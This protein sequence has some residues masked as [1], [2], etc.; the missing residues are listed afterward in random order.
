M[1]STC[2][3]NLRQ[4]Y[5]FRENVIRA[6]A[7][8]SD[9]IKD[10]RTVG[11]CKNLVTTEFFHVCVKEEEDPVKSETDII[12]EKEI[13]IESQDGNVH[14]KESGFCVTHQK[15]TL[16][17]NP[18][19]EENSNLDDRWSTS[20]ST[21]DLNLSNNTQ[22]GDEMTF[23]S[24]TLQLNNVISTLE[25]NSKSTSPKRKKNKFQ[26]RN[27]IATTLSRR[28][29]EESKEEYLIVA[30]KR[31]KE[32]ADN[33]NRFICDQCGNYFTCSHYFKLHLR[34]HAGDRQCACE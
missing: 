34:R 20:D 4:A 15:D 9:Q 21:V 3:Q 14:R 25:E 6:Q 11:E 16:E 5:Q 33:P 1:C 28:G 10:E 2:H 7:L 24:D 31:K 30:K 12:E 32:K 27:K 18:N 22:S 23:R 17:I 29:E 19:E 8:L 13:S 26:K